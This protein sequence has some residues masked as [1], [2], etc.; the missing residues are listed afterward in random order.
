MSLIVLGKLI[1]TPPE[2]DDIGELIVEPTFKNG[3]HVDS[4]YLIPELAGYLVDPEPSNPV[5]SFAGVKTYAYIFEDEQEWLSVLASNTDREGRVNFSP[6]PISPPNAVTRRQFIQ[7]LIHEGI[8]ETVEQS[9][10]AISDVT[11][12]KIMKAWFQE[13]QVFEIDRPELNQMIKEL[14]FTEEFRDEF[15]RRAAKL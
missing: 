5:H 13:S 15:F 10:N 1:D 7:Q 4:T 14:G 6:P 8:D 9:L 3:W 2:Y 12:R 11:H